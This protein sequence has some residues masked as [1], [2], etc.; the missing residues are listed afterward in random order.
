VV[1][2]ICG[3]NC[4]PTASDEQPQQRHVPP[5]LLRLRA[6]VAKMEASRKRKQKKELQFE[7]KGSG[8]KTCHCLKFGHGKGCNKGSCPWPKK[9]CRYPGGP[10]KYHGKEMLAQIEL[11]EMEEQ[12]RLHPSE[13]S[14]VC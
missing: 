10:A 8:C 9:S 14:G 4:L 3:A 13:P 1:N 7:N 11:D 12:E 2:A 5:A 6:K